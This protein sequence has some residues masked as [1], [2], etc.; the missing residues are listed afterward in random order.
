MCNVVTHCLALYDEKNRS[1]DAILSLYLSNYLTSMLGDP[2]SQLVYIIITL[3]WHSELLLH[4]HV[5][6]TAYAGC[7]Y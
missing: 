2:P 5:T 4:F 6:C 1:H 7:A 3:F